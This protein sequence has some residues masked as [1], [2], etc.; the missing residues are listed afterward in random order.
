MPDFAA[1]LRQAMTKN[2]LTN[3]EVA[4][5]VWGTTKD[6]R[7]YNVAKNRDRIGHYLSG[8]SYPEDENLQKIADAIGIP[9]DELKG[10]RR[11]TQVNK[12]IQNNIKDQR[13]T[14]RIDIEIHIKVIPS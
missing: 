13:V 6:S 7:G 8:A 10:E 12:T 1:A 14:I 2:K 5:R 9:V 3:S 4:R 11:T